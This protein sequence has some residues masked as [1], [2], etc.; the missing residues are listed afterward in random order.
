VS[1]GL[2][3]YSVLPPFLQNSTTLF[4]ELEFLR[5]WSTNSNHPLIRPNG[6]LLPT[7]KIKNLADFSENPRPFWDREDQQR[8][9]VRAT[10]ELAW[11]FIFVDWECFSQL[12]WQSPTPT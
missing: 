6:H 10:I 2:H 1:V 4:K 9:W 3:S 8:W 7:E 11:F 12:A 5:S